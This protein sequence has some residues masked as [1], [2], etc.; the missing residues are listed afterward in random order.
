MKKPTRHTSIRLNHADRKALAR[1]CRLTG[2][3]NN[4][5]AIRLAVREAVKARE[6]LCGT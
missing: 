6:G 3:T 4:S 2:I 5:E 1:L